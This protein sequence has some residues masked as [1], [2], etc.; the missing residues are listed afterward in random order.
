M[1]PTPAALAQ[2]AVAA[3]RAGGACAKQSFGD[4][5]SVRRKTDGSEYTRADLDAQAEVIRCILASR[6]HDAILAEEQQPDERAELG[7]ARCC[8]IIDPIDGTRNYI[9][10]VPLYACSVAACM[11]GVPVAGAIFAPQFDVLY[12]AAL[13]GPLCVNGAPNVPQERSGRAKTPLVAIPSAATPRFRPWVEG[14]I[15]RAVLRS[16]GS[17]ALHLAYVA[18]G[19]YDAALCSDS[20]LWDIAA[21]IVLVEAAGGVA[22]GAGNGPLVPPRLSAYANED[23]PCL[24]ARSAELMGALGLQPG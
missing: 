23:T 2:L 16:L 4:P 22:R 18:S 20:K 21:G 6:P 11:D 19:A 10:G 17:T 9:R 15:D 13:G 3:A 1:D 8:W 24:V 5:L 14:L 7:S 12:S